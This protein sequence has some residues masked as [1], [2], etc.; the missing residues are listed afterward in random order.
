MFQDGLFQDDMAQLPGSVIVSITRV[1][2]APCD[3]Y[4]TVIDE[5]GHGNVEIALTTAE[6]DEPVTDDDR[7]AVARLWGK[8]QRMRG[9]TLVDMVGQQIFKE[10]P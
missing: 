2:P 7:K 9:R 4:V 5:D 8:F 1:N 10:I 6:L 3:H